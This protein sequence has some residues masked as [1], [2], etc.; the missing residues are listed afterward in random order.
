MESTQRPDT[1][2]GQSIGAL[3]ARIA[4]VAA[5]VGKVEK[6]RKHPQGYQYFSANAVMGHLVTAMAEN[7]L[8]VIPRVLNREIITESDGIQRW[9]I[10][11]QF[12]IGDS[13]GNTIT[14]D[15][16]GEAPLKVAGKGGYSD[17]KS[18]GKA[19]TY[20][21]KYFLMKLFMV[22]DVETDDLDDNVPDQKAN[23]A[24]A[25][26]A[27]QK[28]APGN[29]ATKQKVANP[30]A[31][32]KA[33]DKDNVD[34]WLGDSADDKW[35]A[36]VRKYC[37]PFYNHVNHRN[38]SINHALEEGYIKREMTAAH[39]AALMLMHCATKPIDDGGLELS[40][41]EALE[42][43]GGGVSSYF[44]TKGNN[45][46]TAWD[47]LKSYD[48]KKSQAAANEDEEQIPF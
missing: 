27:E 23:P 43:L 16:V 12:I 38:N 31:Q 35:L 20:A 11:Y 1:V 15:W 40:E 46:E 2:S 3:F 5:A 44:K 32:P 8:A 9:V 42:A 21:H 37:D 36:D 26:K 4:K 29:A 45:W 6:D 25:P 30:P 34:E 13:D 17:D 18:L 41:D 33:P 14:V 39:A 19:H 47:M 48:L 22:S 10:D 28:P 7:G 24:P